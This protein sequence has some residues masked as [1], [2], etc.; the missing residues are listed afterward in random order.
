VAVIRDEVRMSRPKDVSNMTAWNRLH[1]S[2]THPHPERQLQVFPTPPDHA[3]VVGADVKEELPVD[4]EQPSCH[5]WRWSRITRL[6]VWRGVIVS[7]PSEMSGP[8]MKPI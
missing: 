3:S 2:S 6:S 8:E 4:P 7:L 5:G 1:S